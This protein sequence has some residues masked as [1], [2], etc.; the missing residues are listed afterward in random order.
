VPTWSHEIGPI[1]RKNCV[2]CHYPGGVA[3]FSLVQFADVAKRAKS[4][5]RVTQRRIM[6]P[7]LPSGPKGTF[8]GERGLANDEID[9]IR[10]WIEA[11]A[12]AGGPATAPAT[13][14]P[15]PPA[16]HGAWRLGPPDVI[17]RMPRE[18][19]V[20]AGPGD[21]YQAFVIPL[22]ASAIAPEVRARAQ[23]PDTELL[24]VAGI[25]IH[26]GNRRVVH[27]AHVWV[28]TSGEA[29]RREASSGEVGY[30]AFGNPGF[31]PAA[32]LGGCVP[33]STPRLFP[34]G[35]AEA[36]PLG[37]DLVLQVHYSPSGKPETD[38]TEI[39]IYFVRE[40]VK[41]MLEWLRLG[42]FNIEI[43]A[44]AESYAI[45]DELEIP[46]DC[47][48]ISVSPHMHLLGR[49]VSARAVLPDG[50]ELEL[51][52][53]PRWNFAW[54]DFYRLKE[55]MHLPRGT[56]VRVRWV[57]DNSADNPRNP[58]SPPQPVHFGPN[59]SDEMCEFH[60]FVVPREID[61]YPVFSELMSR[62]MAEK[63]AELTP[64]QRKRFGFDR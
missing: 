22:P 24:G 10:T 45:E 34:P 61:D 4:V 5:M 20:P 47:F 9:L 21:V 46:A 53:I 11:G 63:I 8:E 12:P 29:R 49:E 36:Y 38:Q 59:T 7:W 54:Q 57:F 64:E 44:G 28:D 30:V 19:A 14:Q 31:S 26:P 48:V 40:P 43:P 52:T 37:G 3:P 25:E 39:G 6:P 62:K 58:H 15:E 32:Y 33:G 1:I 50:E 23:I 51:L 41:R 55:P 18:F 56:R 16:D 60:L 13:K 2:E 27:H 17:L 35:I 42:S